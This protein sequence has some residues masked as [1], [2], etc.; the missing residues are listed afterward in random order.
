LAVQAVAVRLDELRLAHHRGK[1]YYYAWIDR[2]IPIADEHGTDSPEW[3]T[4]VGATAP[5]LHDEAIAREAAALVA[6]TFN[7]WK[8]KLPPKSGAV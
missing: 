8:V 4:E 2:L 7:Q 3:K 6:K 1:E 5:K